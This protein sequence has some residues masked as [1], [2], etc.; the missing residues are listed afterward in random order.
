MA[1]TWPTLSVGMDLTSVIKRTVNLRTLNLGDGYVQRIAPGINNAPGVFTIVYKYL[2]QSDATTLLAFLKANSLGQTVIIPNFP[3][4]STGATTGMYYIVDY[5][6]TYG[7]GGM[8]TDFT[9]T[10][11][12]VFV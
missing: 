6:P 9:I 10:A 1:A 3:E 4:D 8:L 12:E 11:Q 7:D 2:K 5:A